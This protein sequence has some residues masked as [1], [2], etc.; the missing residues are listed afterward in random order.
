ME[1]KA[2]GRGGA[3]PKRIEAQKTFSCVAVAV[4]VAVAVAAV[5]LVILAIILLVRVVV[6]IVTMKNSSHKIRG[7]REFR[8][9]PRACSA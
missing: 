4:Q 2:G 7:G 3:Q 5:L 9:R 6:V 1:K 8:I